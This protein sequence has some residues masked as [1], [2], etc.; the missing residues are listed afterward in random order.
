MIKT[1]NF[2]TENLISGSDSWWRRKAGRFIWIL[3]HAGIVT[4]L[5]IGIYEKSQK[6]VF[7]L[8]AADGENQQVLNLEY[9]GRVDSETDMSRVLTGF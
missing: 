3:A 8:I 1:E 9:A 5:E 7:V 2:R 4:D 6:N